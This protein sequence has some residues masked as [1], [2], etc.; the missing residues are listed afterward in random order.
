MSGIDL[1]VLITIAVSAL[2]SLVRGFVREFVSLATWL[3]AIAI[4]VLFTSRFATLLPR[5]TIE[6][7]TARTAISAATLFIGCMLIGSLVS[8]L[9]GRIVAGSRVGLFD[10]IFGVF[11][12][13]AR[14]FLIIALLVLSANLVP[15]LKQET[16][17]RTS[18]FLPNFQVVARFIHARLPIEIGQHFDFSTP[19][20][21]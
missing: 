12:G 21:S 4:T 17:W 5:E 6:S 19:S 14:G 15:T 18:L 13:L 11:F 9:V 7:P 8:W 3:S 20:S 1:V 2:V 16:W 10:R